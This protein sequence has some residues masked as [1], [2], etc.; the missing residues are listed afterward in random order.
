MIWWWLFWRPRFVEYYSGVKRFVDSAASWSWTQV[1]LLAAYILVA[2]AGAEEFFLRLLTSKK[3]TSAEA[4]VPT[5]LFT[6]FPC[7]LNRPL[8]LQFTGHAAGACSVLLCIVAACLE[9]CK[10]LLCT[11]YLAL[12][13]VKLDLVHGEFSAGS[14]GVGVGLRTGVYGG[15]G[16]NKALC[17]TTLSICSTLRLFIELGKGQLE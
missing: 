12:G 5:L 11:K 1:L 17:G 13:L 7:G 14:G 2:P 16:T 4:F 8:L 15:A 9:P 6:F 10:H 3:H